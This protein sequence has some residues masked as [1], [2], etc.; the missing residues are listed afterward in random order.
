MGLAASPQHWGDPALSP[1]ASH[2]ACPALRGKEGEAFRQTEAAACEL[3][4]LSHSVPCSRV[5]L[6]GEQ[7]EPKGRCGFSV[8]YRQDFK[9]QSIQAVSLHLLPEKSPLSSVQG[10]G[11]I[12]TQMLLPELLLLSAVLEPARGSRCGIHQASGSHVR[13]EE[14]VSGS[15]FLGQSLLGRLGVWGGR[16]EEVG[17][18]EE[19]LRPALLL[20]EPQPPWLPPL[21]LRSSKE[22][23][24]WVCRIQGPGVL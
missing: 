10:A 21:R 9:G 11:H 7:E 6:W 24:L 2:P 14:D 1:R 19:E 22:S 8:L 20:A 12:W 18:V 13:T 23:L 3:S 16:E 15:T 5:S 4:A 17:E